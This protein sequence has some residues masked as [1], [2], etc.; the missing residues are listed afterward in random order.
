MKDLYDVATFI[1]K[2]WREIVSRS[3]VGS[4]RI[5]VDGIIESLGIENDEEKRLIS[6]NMGY[7]SFLRMREDGTYEAVT[8]SLR[9]DIPIEMVKQPAH[10]LDLKIPFIPSIPKYHDRKEVEIPSIESETCENCSRY[11]RDRNKCT[12]RGIFRLPY[13]PRCN[14][15]LRIIQTK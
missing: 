13:F 5:T 11:D 15:F 6:E 2:K 3:G 1:R 9:N 14:K 7:F 10:I 8:Y 4:D 12:L